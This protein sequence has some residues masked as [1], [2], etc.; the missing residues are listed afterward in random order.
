MQYLTVRESVRRLRAAGLDVE[1]KTVRS[2]IRERKVRDVWVLGRHTFIYEQ[3][4]DALIAS[5][6]G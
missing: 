1:P 4:L 3:E 5:A 6:R 2:W